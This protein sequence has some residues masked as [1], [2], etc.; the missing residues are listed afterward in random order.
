M[1]ASQSSEPK[2]LIWHSYCI[3]TRRVLPREQRL[4]QGTAS[5]RA[6]AV[7]SA[8]L[9]RSEA[10][11]SVLGGCG[12]AVERAANALHSAGIDAEPHGNLADAFSAPRLP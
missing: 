7:A 12:C 11:V 4:R 3:Y 1:E 9:V 2:G 10:S 8:A 5:A 6:L